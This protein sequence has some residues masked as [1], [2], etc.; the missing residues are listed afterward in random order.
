MEQQDM[1]RAIPKVD[2]AA[3]QWSR[4]RRWQ[5]RCPP[6]PCGEAVREELEALRRRI[7]AG[8]TGHIPNREDLC[9]R[10]MPPG[11]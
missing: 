2:E 8:D 3:G 5:G 10:C 9:A 7:L 4:F 11:P 6:P 1:L